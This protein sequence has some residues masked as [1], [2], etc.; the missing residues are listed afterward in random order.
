MYRWLPEAIES[1]TVIVTASR[2]LARDLHQ[3]HARQQ[4]KKGNDTWRTAQIQFRGD[5]LNQLIDSADLSRPRPVRIDQNASV[6]LWERC[7]ATH[8][9]DPL[10]SFANTVRLCRQTWQRLHEHVVPLAEASRFARSADQQQFARA[11]RAYSETLRSNNWIDAAMLPALV[12]EALESRTILPPAKVLF[13]GFDRLSPAMG[14]IIEK[15]REQDCKV[16]V[17]G[18]ADRNEKLISRTLRD[19]QQ[20]LRAAGHWARQFLR[21]SPHAKLA[22]ICPDL[23]VDAAAAARLVREGLAP[24]WQY[25]DEASRNAVDV[26]YGQRLCDFPAI[27]IALLLL[28]WLQQGLPSQEIGVLLRSPFIVSQSVSGRSRCEL[29][30]RRWPDRAWTPASLASLLGGRD[31]AEDTRRWFAAMEQIGAFAEK[32]RGDASP[33]LWAERFD[34]LLVALGWPGVPVLDSAGYQLMNRWRAMLSEFAATGLVTPRRSM[35][36]AIDRICSMASDII[37]QPQLEGGIVQ[38]LGA[39]EA[40][41]LSFDAAWVCGMDSTRWPPPPNPLALVSRALQEKYS[42]PDATPHDSFEFAELV[43]KRIRCSATEV[44]LSWA[45]SDGETE[46]SPSR[47]LASLS[48]MTDDSLTDPGWHAA[49]LQDPASLVSRAADPAPPVMPGEKVAG[50]ASTVQMQA[51]EPFTAFARGRLRIREIAAIEPG[52]PATLKGSILHQALHAL[53]AGKPDSSTI[54]AWT[55][56][57]IGERIDRA[58]WL[59]LAPARLH[60]DATHRKLLE[61]ERRRLHTIMKKF[62]EAER[63]RPPFAIESVEHGIDFERYGVRLALRVDRIDRLADNSLLIIDYKTG[64][65]KTLMDKDGNLLDLQLVVYAMAVGE[66]IGG[67]VLINVDS[68][69]ITY[70]G[71]GGSVDW[72]PK[73]CADWAERLAAWIKTADATLRKLAKGDVRI[74]VHRLEQ[75]TGNLAIL[76]RVEE[77]KRV[78]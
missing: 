35:T 59:I 43:L 77:L 18:V 72:D 73:R 3:E 45:S 42:M 2:R 76:S 4:I 53:F 8:T 67:V 56:T 9:P 39:L 34:R 51:S 46:L 10:L 58:L 74:D 38:L 30:L 69:A 1:S 19:R 37:F 33:A 57:E 23:Q 26:S 71:T 14:R 31:D 22:I 55:D 5:W 54:V 64:L 52:L 15:L 47:L 44:V 17:A 68:R 50:G 11:A 16:E 24:G 62:V 25:A 48:M 12:A 41:G 63:S 78:G 20:E 6:I 7:L 75:E 27:S 32:H 60:L 28:R 13:T 61:F 65:A 66:P 21:K 36:A 29:E 49:Q 70:K 40:S